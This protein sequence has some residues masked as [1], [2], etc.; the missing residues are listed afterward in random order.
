[1]PHSRLGQQHNLAIPDEPFRFPREIFLWYAPEHDRAILATKLRMFDW[2]FTR[3]R[4]SENVKAIFWER[5]TVG[6][7]YPLRDIVERGGKKWDHAR[8]L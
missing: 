8:R 3:L 5:M 4:R 2:L 1:M 7:V 6:H